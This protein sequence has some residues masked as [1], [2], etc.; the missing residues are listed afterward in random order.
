MG[1]VISL[2]YSAL[3]MKRAS[4]WKVLDAQEVLYKQEP[5]RV[6]VGQSVREGLCIGCEVGVEP[7]G[8]G[9]GTSPRPAPTLTP[10]H[11]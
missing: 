5:F 11:S 7:W 4:I 10:C 1:T 2:P 9:H 6:H 3:R 8:C